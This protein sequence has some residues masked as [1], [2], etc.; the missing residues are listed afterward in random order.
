[1]NLSDFQREQI[2]NYLGSSNNIEE[3]KLSSSVEP[4]ITDLSFFEKSQVFKFL[5]KE[6]APTEK[7]KVVK[8]IIEKPIEIQKE[9]IVKKEI[10]ERELGDDKIQEIIKTIQSQ[11]IIPELPTNT[12]Q[13]ETPSLESIVDA[14]KKDFEFTQKLR[15]PPKYIGGGGLGEGDVVNVID[16]ERPLNPKMFGLDEDG[17]WRIREDGEHLRVEYQD[18]GIW[19]EQGEFFVTNRAVDGMLMT[20]DE[21]PLITED[22]IILIEE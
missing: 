2:Q 5:T 14:L 21:N 12:V 9:V 16:R 10:V 22:N 17:T 1:V 3:S 15:T 19:M 20:E 18:D 7:K 13:E 11:I 4:D 8:K 6:N